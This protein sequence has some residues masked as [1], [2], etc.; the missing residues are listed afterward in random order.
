MIYGGGVVILSELLKRYVGISYDSTTSGAGTT[1]PYRVSV[2]TPVLNGVRVAR[3]FVFLCGVLQIVVCPFYF[4]QLRCLSFFGL[5]I[6]LTPLMSS[7][8]SYH[9]CAYLL[10]SLNIILCINTC[11][12]LFISSI[13]LPLKQ[14]NVSIVQNK[15][16]MMKY[17]IYHLKEYYVIAK[18]C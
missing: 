2:F 6:L 18:Q 15:H 7:N 4:W 8:A 14:Q 1:Y 10:A 12:H 5:W 17:I 9:A 3:S 13:Q 11:I 16:T